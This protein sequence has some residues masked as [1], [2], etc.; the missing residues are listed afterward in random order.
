MPTIVQDSNANAIWS[1]HFAADPLSTG[2]TSYQI[3]AAQGDDQPSSYRYV[4]QVSN[5]GA[6]NVSL[7]PYTYA[8]MYLINPTRQ[9]FLKAVPMVGSQV[10]SVAAAPTLVVIQ[11]AVP[12]WNIQQTLEQG[13][14]PTLLVGVDP[15]S[16][17]FYPMNVVADGGGFKLST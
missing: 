6:G 17:L 1:G 3:L 2:I 16:G 7:G 8:R 5:P 12:G 10:M 15:V 4:D 13:M 14:R 11:S 9:F